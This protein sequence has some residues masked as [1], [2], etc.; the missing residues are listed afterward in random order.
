MYILFI[1]VR[2]KMFDTRVSYLCTP[3]CRY[4]LNPGVN[5]VKMGIF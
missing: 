5:W 3:G 1:F 4:R 2:Q